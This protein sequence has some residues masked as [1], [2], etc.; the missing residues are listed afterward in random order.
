MEIAKYIAFGIYMVICLV[1]VVLTLVQKQDT[2][3]ASGTIVGSSTNNYYEKNK[4]RTSQ[5]KMKR[6]T[7]VLSIVF[8][9]S[10]IALGIL[11]TI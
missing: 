3:G 10:A 4:S 11:F 1:L 6:A 8:A 9:V 2:R 5:G 7:V